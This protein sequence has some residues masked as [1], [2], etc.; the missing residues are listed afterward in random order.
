MRIEIA[1][2][3]VTTAMVDVLDTLQNDRALT[4]ELI[5]ALDSV[6]RTVILDLT[7]IEPDADSKVLS[8]LR[9]LQLIRRHLLTLSSPPDADDPA[10]DTPTAQF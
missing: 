6:T 2:A 7:T 10:N 4:S 3:Q 5:A 8:T 1:G 9:S